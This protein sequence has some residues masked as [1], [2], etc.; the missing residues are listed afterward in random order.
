[1]P[2]PPAQ[3]DTAAT[4]ETQ[5]ASS[6]W[7]DGPMGNAKHR[8]DDFF[9]A[10]SGRLLTICVEATRR[11]RLIVSREGWLSPLPW[12]PSHCV[13]TCPS[14]STANPTICLNFVI[15]FRPRGVCVS[16]NAMM[17]CSG[18]THAY[19]PSEPLWPYC[20]FCSPQP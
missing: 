18:S 11:P 8:R 9:V 4:R 12:P 17:P 13:A 14:S 1:M 2:V 19:V 6:L 3:S 7:T 20:P 15:G 16:T 5:L 10:A